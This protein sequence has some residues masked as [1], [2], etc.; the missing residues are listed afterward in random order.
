MLSLSA[1]TGA[2]FVNMRRVYLTAACGSLELMMP[3]CFPVSD[4]ESSVLQRL[5]TLSL[6][7]RQS[8]TKT[9]SCAKSGQRQSLVQIVKN[10]FLLSVKV[11]SSTV[12]YIRGDATTTV[13]DV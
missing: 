10:S 2:R 13:L 5:E 12:R 3:N 8:L 7:E 9:K 1:L 4:S 11:K 6:C